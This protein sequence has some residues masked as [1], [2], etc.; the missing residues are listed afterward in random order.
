MN[1][2]DDNTTNK[3]QSSPVCKHFE[4]TKLCEKCFLCINSVIFTTSPREQP[5][6]TDPDTER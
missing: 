5:Q 1:Q 3:K 6:A 4:M 2:I